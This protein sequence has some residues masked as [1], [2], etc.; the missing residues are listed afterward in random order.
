MNDEEEQKCECPPGLPAWMA[1]FADLM[2]LLM[3]FFVLLLSF[4]EMD[5]LKFKRLAGSMREAFGVQAIVNVDS[6]PKGTSII[7]Q[8]FSPG[9]P[10]PTPL[11]TIMQQT[12][13]DLPNLQQLCEQQVA[14]ALQEECPKIQ[15]E[16]LSDIVLEKIKM[17]VEETENDAIT[18]ASALEAEVRNN[19][20]E[21]ETRGRKIVIRVQEKGSFNSGSADLNPEFYPVIDKLVE[22]L[23][24]MA[25]SISVEGHSDSI[26]IHTA[27]FR[28]NWDL[29]AARALEVAHALFESGELDPSRFSIAGYADTKPLASNDSAENRARNRRV[30]IILQQ[31]LDDETKKEIQKA[32]D[33]APDILPRDQSEEWQGLAPDEIF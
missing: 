23:K 30:E 32:R 1:T 17:L 15:G 5:A 22:L 3:C 25:G 29:S 7:A 16:E 18:L 11:Q 26:P 9:K 28:S 10:D 12:E 20:V 19:Q 27:R 4:S 14:D 21:V 33:V 6:I 31:P 2:S 13:M 24:S 8:E